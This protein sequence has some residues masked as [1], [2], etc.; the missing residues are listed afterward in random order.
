MTIR[1]LSDFKKKFNT[2][3]IEADAMLLLLHK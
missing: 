1:D 3:I 2:D